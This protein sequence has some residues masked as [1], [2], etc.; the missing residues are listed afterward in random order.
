MNNIIYRLPNALVI[1]IY[2][3]NPEHRQ[4]YSKV[5]KELLSVTPFWYLY[6]YHHELTHTHKTRHELTF[7]QAY[8]LC[9]YWN[10]NFL[11]QHPYAKSYHNR[12]NNNI[13]KEICTMRYTS[14]TNKNNFFKLKNNI[15]SYRYVNNIKLKMI[16]NYKI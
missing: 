14:D 2:E 6:F 3:Y 4:L 10:I 7:K 9:R 12:Y 5:M 13:Y 15:N 1:K 8:D 16:K 11:K